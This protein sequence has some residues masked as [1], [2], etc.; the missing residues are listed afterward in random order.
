MSDDF[1]NA[2]AYAI[3]A[4]TMDKIMVFYGQQ[5]YGEYTRDTA[6]PIRELPDGCYIWYP[7]TPG[8]YILICRSLTPINLCDIPPEVKLNCLL[9]GITI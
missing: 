6:P 4:L 3:G 9:L 8:W 5:V 7:E 1:T 2:I